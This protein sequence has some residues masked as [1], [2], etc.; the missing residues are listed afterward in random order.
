MLNI[1]G[2]VPFLAP[3]G[4]TTHH[5]LHIFAST[6]TPEGGGG[7]HSIFRRLFDANAPQVRKNEEENIPNNDM[8][9]HI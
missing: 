3:T 8:A 4:K 9:Y 7:R 2:R 5:R 1:A 6:T